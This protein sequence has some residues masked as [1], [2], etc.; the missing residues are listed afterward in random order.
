MPLVAEPLVS[1]GIYETEPVGCEAG[2][3]K[4]LN[5]VIEFA[6]HGS[7]AD[8]LGE[9]REIETALGR[10]S[11]HE[12]NRSRT[13]DLDLLY[14]GGDLIE[15]PDL[16]LPHPRIGDRRFVLE[17]LAELH[18]EL[19]LPGHASSVRDMLA[20]LPELPAVVRSAAQW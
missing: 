4:F 14:H 5:A 18:P 10:P 1:S 9:L 2:A 11:D 12:R 19:V 20:A 8:L 13:V 15:T 6:H 17:P 16:H 3:E 7:A